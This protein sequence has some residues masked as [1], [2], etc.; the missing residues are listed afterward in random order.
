[1]ASMVFPAYALNFKVKAPATAEAFMDVADLETVTFSPETN[2]ETYNSYDAE[3]WQ[4]ALATGKSLKITISGKRSK[5]GAGNDALAA[6]VL[7]NG[8]DCDVIVQ[9]GFPTGET[10][11]IPAVADVKNIGGGDAND[12]GGLEVE[13]TSNGKPTETKA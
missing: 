6:L 5:D 3:G 11:E 10:Y 1:M 12:I 7:K 4:K 8:H 13:F 2:I 9:V